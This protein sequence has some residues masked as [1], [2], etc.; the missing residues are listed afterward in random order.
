MSGQTQVA[1]VTG[2]SSGIGLETAVQ[3]AGAG[4]DVVATVRDV[5]RA[6][7]LREAAEAAGV[8]LDVRSLDITSDASSEGCIAQVLESRGRIDL[9]VNNAGAGMVGTL[10]QLSLD[11]LRSAFET[12]CLGVARLTKLVL[13]HMRERGSGRI[14]TVTSV[15]GVVGQP[16]NEAY[17][18][19]KFAVEGMM[20]ALAPVAER[21]GVTV[22]VVEPAAVASEFATSALSESAGRVGAA[23]DAYSSLLAAYRRRTAAA[24]ASAQSS[25]HAAAAVVAACLDPAPR[26]RYQ[27]SD[28]ASAF[29]GLSVADLDGEQVLAVTR[30][31]LT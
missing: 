22:S 24:F 18:A 17:C 21:M 1:L 23:E 25:R 8:S 15:G 4:V 10:E 16:F 3:L 7:R 13:P 12:N 27:T 30:T 9:L 31:W 29:A 26:F 20:Q 28:T 14:V 5:A 11:D 19:A 2:T 6:A